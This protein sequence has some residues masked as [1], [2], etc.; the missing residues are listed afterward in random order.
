MRGSSVRSCA[1]LRGLMIISYFYEVH[2]CVLTKFLGRDS[3]GATS[4]SCCSS[5]TKYCSIVSLVARLDAHLLTISVL[6]SRHIL[7][8]SIMQMWVH[9]RSL[10]LSDEEGVKAEWRKLWRRI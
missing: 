8:I 7:C 6:T 3:T 10:L 2:A 5:R 9:T 1:G 4:L